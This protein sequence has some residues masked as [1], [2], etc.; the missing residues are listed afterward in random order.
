LSTEAERCLRKSFNVFYCL[1]QI[2]KNLV[3][4][5]RKD[6]VGAAMAEYAVLIGLITLALVA[7]I[8]PFR[9]AIIAVFIAVTAA[10]AA[11]A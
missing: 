1:R 8:I 9:D 3:R 11:A 4:R 2:M 5:L 7:I 10:L 6:D